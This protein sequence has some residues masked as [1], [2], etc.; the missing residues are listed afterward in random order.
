MHLIRW[1]S[2]T[3]FR[4]TGFWGGHDGRNLESATGPPV[5]LPQI[6]LC[7]PPLGSANTVGE[8]AVGNATLTLFREPYGRCPLKQLNFVPPAGAAI[9]GSLVAVNAS[10]SRGSDR[11]QPLPSRRC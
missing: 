8:A 3:T 7:F 1:F 10:S 11:R 2:S 5:D 4:S 6:G 9:S